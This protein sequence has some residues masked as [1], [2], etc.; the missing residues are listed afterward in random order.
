MAPREGNVSVRFSVQDQEKVRAAL[1]SLGK[2]GEATMRKLEQAGQPSSRGLKS[3][4]AVVDDLKGK[5]LSFVPAA[6]L[7]GAAMGPLGAIGLAV[8]VGI[9][10]VIVAFER[11][12][13]RATEF[14]KRMHELKESAETTGLS[15]TQLKA[16]I[17]VGARTGS[18]SAATAGFI[19]RLTV[20]FDQLR[21]GTG[22]LLDELLKINPALALQLSGAKDTAA[23]I[24]LLARA[25]KSAK[26]QAE[27]NA[28]GRAVGGRGGIQGGQ[29]LE[30]V[31]S[32]GGVATI[33][34]AA[35]AA[36]KS[37]DEEYVQRIAN[38][39]VEIEETKK[40]VRDL[41]DS[42]FSE[43]VLE[44]S[45]QI[46]RIQESIT[47]AIINQKGAVD[48]AAQ[49]DIARG[50]AAAVMAA[51]VRRRAIT[52]DASA[53]ARLAS[54]L[55][56]GVRSDLSN[57]WTP[58]SFND[59]S[60]GAPS[61]DDK[62]D[63]AGQATAAV[64]LAIMQRWMSVLGTAATPAEQLR[65]K[66]LELSAAMEKGG[67]SAEV[68][69]RAQAA[70][71]VAHQQSIVAV[72]EQLGIATEEEILNVRR[73]E[74]NDRYS[75]GY[76]RNAQER[77]VADRIAS[78]E[79][80]ESAQRMAVRASLNPQLMQLGIE[81]RD[82]SKNLDQLAASSLNSVT[83]G[84]ADM[85]T[86]AKSA[87]EAFKAMA[88]SIIRDIVRMVIKQQVVGPIASALGNF[89]LTK[90][91]SS[92]NGNAFDA[93]RIT[94]FAGGGILDRPILFKMANGMGLAGEAGPEAV[95]P[96]RRTAGGRLGVEASGAG[97]AVQLNVN[98]RNEPGV[99]SE[100]QDDGRGGLMVRNFI[101]GIKSEIADDMARNRGGISRFAKRQPLRG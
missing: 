35:K 39:R 75:K 1:A 49:A 99:R 66:Q 21:R 62:T 34:A 11:A 80:Q 6:G 33:T 101:E 43:P 87:G 76:I 18:D 29:L 64:Q 23:A 42:W 37:I 63:T 45:L 95:M 90:M 61:V 57:I 97:G 55:S 5:V 89:D 77:A 50:N 83:E 51:R 31:A 79:A 74:L 12:S 59:P 96:L 24:D 53:R 85:A 94:A 17:E 92:A 67:V 73:A 15:I 48:E 44:R 8:A 40:R 3:V 58:P 82:L 20:S 93:G 10:A 84:L 86:G 30:A 36:G 32:G 4:G 98:V 72:R 9:G 25:Y 88:D 52:D 13:E 47:R 7:A 26:D 70:L 41:Q 56:S 78:R 68:A 54:G 14:A 81:A 28:L 65:L 19:E 46:L 60:P 100:V 91:F 27:R 22:P 2:D 38:L 16:L 71:A 69:A